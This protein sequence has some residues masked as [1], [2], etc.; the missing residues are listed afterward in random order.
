MSSGNQRLNKGVR[1]DPRKI[2]KKISGI[3]KNKILKNKFPSKPR[4]TST[5]PEIV[6][7]AN[8][9]AETKVHR[10]W[11]NSQRMCKEY[12]IIAEIARIVSSTLQIG[13]VYGKFSIEVRKLIPSDRLAINL[14]DSET[15]MLKLAYVSGKEIKGRRVG[16]VLPME[17]SVNEILIRE[18]KG[19]LIRFNS[20]KRLKSKFPTLLSAYKAGFRSI[21]SVPL[22]YKESV[23]GGL[24]FLSF[25]PQIYNETDLRLA[26]RIVHQI[27]GAIAN[28]LLYLEYQKK[29]RALRE[30]E[31]RYRAIVEDQTELVNRFLPDFSLTFVNDATCRYIGRSREELIG[32]S[33]MPFL[34]KKD[35][36]R[37]REK[38]S[39]LTPEKPVAVLEHQVI[40]PS[41]E[42]NWAQWINRAIFDN[43][44]RLIEYQSVGRD[45]TGLK[46]IEQD[47]RESKEHYKTLVE[48]QV[49]AVCLWLPDTTLTF[50]NEGYCRFLGKSREE[51]LGKK[52]MDLV[53]AET[54]PK[55]RKKVQRLLTTRKIMKHETEVIGA[56][57]QILYQ[58]WIDCPIFDSS[59]KLI[60]VQSVG[61]DITESKQLY[62]K[63][64]RSKK[65]LRALSVRL[66]E[67]REEERTRIA[68]EIHDDLGQSLTAIK[69][70]LNWLFQKMPAEH[71]MVEKIQTMLGMID[72]TIQSVRRIVSELRPAILDDAGLVPAIEWQ[73]QIFQERT[74]IQFEI[75]TIKEEFPLDK[76]RSTAAF[77]IFQEALTNVARH[78]G[79]TRV[80]IFLKESNKSFLMVIKD[81]GKGISEEDIHNVK[82]LG[83][84]GMQERTRLFG[85]EFKIQGRPTKGTCISVLI[86]YAPI[87][88]RGHKKAQDVKEE[89]FDNDF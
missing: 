26:L 65:Q 66:Q 33:F 2:N 84:L 19:V 77:R 29:E 70:D 85:G 49:E 80:Q 30:S 34:F 25:D 24:H 27:S 28:A 21:I 56:N 12:M 83:L 46:N 8:N 13:E 79:A 51:L 47:L 6:L 45:I 9:N 58:Q 61:R 62:E 88:S 57:G 68:R 40:L 14:L 1:R 82:S 44:G 22:I 74:G 50:V 86:P 55:I 60:E 87:G 71:P 16:S 78:S 23:I 32:R 52:W 48:T 89:R 4:K 67:A 37:V 69:L 35:Q 81:N 11:V 39:S 53:P 72:G 64:R 76:N 3:S 59:G 54:Q 41:G 73:G 42:I 10:A 18:R 15:G 5:L 31:S 38:L 75:N 17:N 7:E 43:Q 36:E 20:G 63:I